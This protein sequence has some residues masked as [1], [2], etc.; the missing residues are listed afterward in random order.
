M[1]LSVFFTESAMCDKNVFNERL[2]LLIKQG[3]NF[4]RV[5]QAK[6]K[7]SD[8]STVERLTYSKHKHVTS[9]NWTT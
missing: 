2:R 1:K 5:Y 6:W 4:F 7:I 8:T 3:F 9:N